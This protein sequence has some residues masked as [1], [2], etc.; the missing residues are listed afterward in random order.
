[1]YLISAG[2]LGYIYFYLFLIRS[3]LFKKFPFIVPPFVGAFSTVYTFFLRVKTVN[4]TAVNVGA[5]QCLQF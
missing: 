1:M 5:Y 3:L 2:S 4:T